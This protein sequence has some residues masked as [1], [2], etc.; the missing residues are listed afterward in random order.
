MV[1]VT[2]SYFACESLGVNCAALRRDNRYTHTPAPPATGTARY[3]AHAPLGTR[4]PA[5]GLASHRPSAR[6][7]LARARAHAARPPAAPTTPNPQS[8]SMPQATPK[9]H[10]QGLCPH[11]AVLPH[12]ASLVGTPDLRLKRAAA[13]GAAGTSPTEKQVEASTSRRLR[14]SFRRG[15]TGHAVI[16]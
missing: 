14:A 12:P 15:G 7:P 5:S 13:P 9:C 16:F 8:L 1:V 6:R 3:I 10:T 11:P 4:V 2:N